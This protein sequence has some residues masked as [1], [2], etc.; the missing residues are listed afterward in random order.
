MSGIKFGVS[1]AFL[2]SKFGDNF[3]PDQVCEAFGHIKRLGFDCYQAEIVT[4][5]KLALWLTGGA[6][7][8]RK[9]AD[10]AGLFMSQFVA[11]FMLD[12]FKDE[13]A[14]LSDY[15]IAEMNLVFDITAVLNE[16]APITVPF[17]GYP[18]KENQRIYQAMVEKM[19]IIAAEANS[20]GFKLSI[21]VQPGALIKGA[22]GIKQ[23]VDSVG[24]N[25]GYNLDTGHAWASGYDVVQYPQLLEGYIYG[26]H[27]CDNDGITNSS[28]R[29]GSSTI[30]FQELLTKLI[31]SGYNSSLDLEIFTTPDRIDEEYSEGLAYIKGLLGCK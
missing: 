25:T 14:V 20:R 1:P 15:G 13:A 17:G 21:E 11:H 4:D 24:Y 26:T 31:M 16:G 19:R 8:V 27:L 29:P 5:D 7:K 18:E 9:T 30:D 10:N 23:F 28:L 2:L 6:K 22:E 12:A 3:T